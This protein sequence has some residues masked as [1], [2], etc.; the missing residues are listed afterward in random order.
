MRS[1]GRLVDR[2]EAAWQLKSRK[3]LDVPAICDLFGVD[4]STLYRWIQKVERGPAPAT[5]KGRARKVTTERAKWL[6]EFAVSK[7]TASQADM[8][9]AFEDRFGVAISH[10]WVSKILQEHGVTR[11]RLRVMSSEAAAQPERHLAFHEAVAGT[12]ETD[13]ASLD[14]SSFH[15]N[16]SPS[17]GYARRGEEA[18]VE[19]SS[20]RGTKLTL[21]VCVSMVPRPGNFSGCVVS[22]AIYEGSMDNARFVRFLSSVGK[23]RRDVPGTPSAPADP[24]GPLTVI[25]DNAGFHGPPTQRRRGPDGRWKYRDCTTTKSYRAVQAAAQAGGIKLAYMRPRSPQFNPSENVLSVVKRRVSPP[26]S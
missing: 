11:K 24:P 2:R 23:A 16:E 13:L 4:R 5:C 20:D 26:A 17:Y 18:R 12:D 7:V 1:A 9:R 8:A 15:I 6:A 10:Q 22:Y 21:A 25:L 14:E 3:F 19:R